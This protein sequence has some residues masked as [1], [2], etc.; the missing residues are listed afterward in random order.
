MTRVL[1]TA[2]SVILR[3]GL[4]AI[5]ATDANLE[6]VGKAV[7]WAD[8][9]Q[10]IDLLQ[11][12]VVLAEVVTQDDLPNLLAGLEGD[13]PTP[14][15]VLLV[16]D[17]Q[18]E[19]LSEAV[20]LGVRGVLPTEANLRGRGYANT[21]EIIAAIE[22]AAAGLFTLHPDFAE[23]LLSNLPA[24]R[25]TST[26][27]LSSLTPREVEVLQML[28]EGLGNKAIARRLQISEHTVKFHIG[29]LFTK[30]HASSRTEAVMLGARQ[31]LILL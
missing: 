7:D 29:S 13:V 11:P 17:F 24:P 12:D 21:T 25:S 28:A 14:A 1:V 16:D 5:I 2:S 30:L 22:A 9:A 10:Q 18:T 27:A 4:E 15:I 6:V 31:G 26:M 19:G 20:R 23:S 8:L 3:A